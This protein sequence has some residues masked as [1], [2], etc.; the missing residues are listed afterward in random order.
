MPR[1]GFQLSVRT[2]EGQQAGALKATNERVGIDRAR[3]IEYIR[4]SRDG[5]GGVV[6]DSILWTFDWIAP[7][8]IASLLIHVSANAANDDQ[9]E[10]GDAVY[11]KQLLIKV[12]QNSASEHRR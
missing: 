10:F 12:P 8:S 7:D 11:Q 2:E 5:T 4:H 1:A 3:G 6:S 9:S